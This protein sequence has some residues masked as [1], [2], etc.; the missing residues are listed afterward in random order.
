MLFAD[1]SNFCKADT[2]ANKNIQDLLDKYEY[3]SRQK[4]NRDKTSMV[5]SEDVTTKVKEEI[6]SLWDRNNV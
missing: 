2:T 1:D 3:A 4:I 6:M 5:F